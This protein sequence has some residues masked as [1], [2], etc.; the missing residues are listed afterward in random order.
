MPVLFIV[1]ALILPNF[2]TS[3]TQAFHGQR[4]LAVVMAAG[5]YESV[6]RL[7]NEIERYRAQSG[8]YPTSLSVMAATPGF[9]HTKG[10]ISTPGI[11][12]SV[13]AVADSVWS[14]NRAMVAGIDNLHTTLPALL[15]SNSCG[16]G[17]FSVA[18]DWCAG[19]Q[20]SDW[21]KTEDRSVILQEITQARTRLNQTTM[22]FVAAW[23]AARSFPAGSL[24]AGGSASLASLVGTTMTADSCTGTYIFAGIPLECGDLF[25]LWGGPVMYNY[26]NPKY[27]AL[28]VDTPFIYSAGGR[29]YVAVEMHY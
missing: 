23:N 7:A 29:Q 22:K 14:F 12:Y 28:M 3:L 24:S 18:S 4:L 25:S 10:F 20:F 8:Q 6:Q 9:E 5:R 27:I 13:T 21:Y 15:L 19:P 11:G 1:L 26:R 16:T 17:D 2:M